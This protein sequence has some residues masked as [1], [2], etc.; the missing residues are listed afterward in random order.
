MALTGF[1]LLGLAFV[2]GFGGSAAGLAQGDGMLVYG[3]S[4]VVT[5]RYRNWIQSL[6]TWNSEASAATAAATIRHTATQT[7]PVRNE[8]ISGYQTTGGTLYI[9]RWDGANWT[10][11]WSIAVGNSSTPRFDIAYEQA[12]GQA[13]V[14]YST[15]TG[16]TNELAYRLWDGTSWT[17]A[18]TYDAVRTLG[19]VDSVKLASRPGSN[20]IAAAW[21]D[22]SFD[23]SANFWDGSTNLWATEPLLALSTN[24]SKVGAAT[25]LTTRSFDVAFE[26]SS[27]ELLVAWGVDAVLD[28]NYVTRGAGTAGVWGTSTINTSFT[29]E[30]TDFEL[31]S[32]PGSDYVAYANISDNGADA[33]AGIWN[34]SAWVN[35]TNFDTTCGTVIAGSANIAVSWLSSGGQSRA[36]VTY[37]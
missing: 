2:A 17:A 9:Q 3:E 28:L 23:M 14:V 37:E 32:E 18:T 11:E 8:V 1:G 22:L 6:T 30:P 21:G 4:T 12:S 19:I 10:A 26:N 33:D 36:V 16:T 13:L 25:S 35:V 34:G 31:A 24:L 15:N 27:G 29:E 20:D 5:P 7:S